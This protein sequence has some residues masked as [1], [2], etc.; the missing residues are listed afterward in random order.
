M[1]S[2]NELKKRLKKR[3]KKAAAAVAA[4]RSNTSS[5]AAA[6]G[7]RPADT[8]S[9]KPAK[10]EELSIDPNAMYNQG[11]L[12]DVYK[13][14]PL[15]EV[16]TRFPPEPNGYLHVYLHFQADAPPSSGKLTWRFSSGTLRLL[17]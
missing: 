13:L 5:S 2:K 14:R 17:Q 15:K 9:C 16:V 8:P 4:A 1:V 12:A 10:A 7:Q 11:F 3:A 6:A